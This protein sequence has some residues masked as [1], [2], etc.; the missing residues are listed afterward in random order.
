MPT[1]KNPMI[2]PIPNLPEGCIPARITA[3]HKDRYEAISAQGTVHAQ[4]KRAAY[5]KASP[6]D[7]PT[8]GDLV[9]LEYRP[10]GDS[11]IHATEK[12]LRPPGSGARVHAAGRSRQL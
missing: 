4:C 8:V 12:L 3:Q 7:C 5:R 1:T 9:A 11:L 10:D 2:P 6:W